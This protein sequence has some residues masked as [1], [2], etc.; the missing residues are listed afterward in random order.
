MENCIFCKIIE[1]KI[2]SPRVYEDENFIVIRDINPLYKV[3]DLIITKKH[4]VSVN[5]V[6]E[7]DSQIFC[8]IFSIAKKI[9]EIENVSAEG[10]RLVV[11]SGKNAGQLVPHFH[12]HLLAGEKLR[13]L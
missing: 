8:S 10:F 5:E 4:I 1:G 3:H 7:S 2:P 11:N 13:E 6:V 12:M 9:A